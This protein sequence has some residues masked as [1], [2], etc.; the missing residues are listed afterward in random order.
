ML[1][2]VYNRLDMMSVTPAFEP[3]LN[4]PLRKDVDKA[5]DDLS[6]KTRSIGGTSFAGGYRPSE[7]VEARK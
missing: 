1:Q 2:N 3:S 4:Q 7:D 6:D 5:F